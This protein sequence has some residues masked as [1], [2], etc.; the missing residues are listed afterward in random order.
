MEKKNRVPYWHNRLIMLAGGISAFLGMVVLAGWYIHNTKLIQILPVFV[1][2]QYNTALCF[3]LCGVALFG[4]ALEKTRLAIACG[5]LAGIVGLLTLA[6]YIS[7]FS[8]G[9]DQFLMEHYIVVETSQPGRMAPNTALCFLLTSAALFLWGRGRLFRR[10]FLLLVGLGGLI[11]VLGLM[12]FIGYLTGS[13]SAYGWGNLTRMAVHT[14]VG[15]MVLGIGI[16]IV[17][18]RER[19]LAREGSADLPSRPRMRIFLL[20]TTIMAVVTFTVALNIVREVH[21][22]AVEQKRA[23]LL[24]L[25]MNWE[26]MVGALDQVDVLRKKTDEW[27]GIEFP[28]L[29]QITAIDEGFLRLEETGEFVMARR[30][31]EQIVF[32]FSQQGRFDREPPST[33]PFDSTLA[34]PMRRAILGESG[35]LIGFDYAG[36]KVLAAYTPFG[37]YGWGLVKKVD[38]EEIAAPFK[39]ASLLAFGIGFIIVVLGAFALLFV[40]DPTIHR[41]EEYVTELRR[42]AVRRLRIEKEL[43]GSEERFRMICENAPVLINAFDENGR[44]VLWNTQCRETFGWTID[45]INSFDNALALFYPDPIVCA[46]VLMSVTNDP[47]GNFKE[48]NPRTKEGRVLTTSWANFRLPSGMVF[49]LGHDI[50]ERK[51]AEVELETHRKHL[52]ELVRER[53]FQLDERITE[54][55][56]L[57]SAMA[58]VMEDMRYSNAKLEAT[59]RAL[60]ASNKE[61]E[62]FSYSVSHDLRAPLRHVDGFVKLL[63]KHEQGNLDS[64]TVRYLDIIATSASRMGN[65]IDDL[66]AFSRT[67]RIALNLQELDSN[68]LVQEVQ[69]ELSPPT[70]DRRITWKID[71]LPV[72][73]A[74]RGLIRQ[75]WGNL[76]GNA[77]KY[78]GQR[79]N[80]C[81]EI[82]TT[83]KEDNIGGEEIT[84][85]IRDNGAGFDPRYTHKLFG[86]FQRLHSEDEFEGTGIGLAIVRRIVYRHGGRVWA[87]GKVGNGATFYFTL[88]TKRGEV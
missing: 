84:F 82:G 78:S 88:N 54:S 62:S 27:G 15:I 5:T 67:G 26:E 53:T 66:L 83:R 24:K 81:I 86:V 57:N 72:V 49:S 7:G 74:D 51:Q 43:G 12:A 47:N 56:E 33:V 58:N 14:A 21:H 42:E 18:F 10:I 29:R 48:W 52:T 39:R 4:V 2:M 85:F 28:T 40:V 9:I 73:M 38:M 30:E 65:L 16:L 87:E 55:E 6:E 31:G 37:Q 19:L 80:A 45:E 32:L 13:S 34:E 20:S 3:L 8:L 76:M 68:A 59:G 77:I 1:P 23:E 44:C 22:A 79:E 71:D 75:V 64:T 70:A 69:Q 60:M 63:L 35:T 17:A 50:T 61:L 41:M 11:F 36:E 46:E 25:V